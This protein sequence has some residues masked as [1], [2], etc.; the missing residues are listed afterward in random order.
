MVV[1]MNTAVFWIKHCSLMEVHQ[2]IAGS[3][4]LQHQRRWIRPHTEETNRK[5]K[6]ASQRRV[7]SRPMGGVVGVGKQRNTMAPLK[8]QRIKGNS[9]KKLKKEI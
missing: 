9:E 7:L 6:R 1:V 3:C 4:C 5:R 8:E 2:H